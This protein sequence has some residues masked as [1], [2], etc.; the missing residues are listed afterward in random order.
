MAE[1]PNKPNLDQ[2][3]RQAKE[4][5]RAAVGGYAEAVARIGAVSDKPSLASAQLAIAR[6]HG[7]RSWPHLKAAVDV[8]RPDLMPSTDYDRRQ[9][10]YGAD[11]FLASARSR[12]WKPGPLPVGAVFTSQ[13]FITGFLE[14]HPDRFRVSKHLAPTNGRVFLTVA[15]PVVAIACLGLGAPAAVTHLEHLA[16]LGVRAAIAV[17][18]APAVCHAL[19]WGDCVVATAGVRDDGVSQHYL[20]PA[21]HAHPA[22]GLTARLAAEAEIAGLDPILGTVWTVPTPYRTAAEDL[23]MHRA[24]GV[25]AT[26]LSTAALFAVGAAL[27]VKVASAVIATRTL[28]AESCSLPP[29]GRGGRVF[30]L[31]D[32]AVRVLAKESGE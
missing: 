10:V 28:G 22:P 23:E 6:E 31:L 8:S 20:P 4:L 3:R 25:L 19:Q 21:R 15:E 29:D 32:V 24:D 9:A 17:G 13:T 2:L 1:L 11:D 30:A 18:P 27:E 7:F 16:G 26:D 5:R 14:E 12:G